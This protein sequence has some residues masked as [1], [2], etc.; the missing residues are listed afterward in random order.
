M[1]VSL[2]GEYEIIV[3][4]GILHLMQEIKKSVK[5]ITKAQLFTMYSNI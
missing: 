4:F 3:H 5:I 1:V 2:I